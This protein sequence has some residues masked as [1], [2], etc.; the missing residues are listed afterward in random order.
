[1]ICGFAIEVTDIRTPQYRSTPLIA[2]AT[3]GHV[4]VLEYLLDG[5]VDMK[6]HHSVS[7]DQ[8]RSPHL[9]TEYILLAHRRHC[10]AP[11]MC[12]SS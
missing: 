8:I 5:G 2:A 6:S 11:R 1:M 4:P 3:K 7:I 9:V 12:K 10:T